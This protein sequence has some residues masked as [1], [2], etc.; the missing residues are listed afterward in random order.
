MESNFPGLL[1]QDAA[2]PLQNL[3][4]ASIHS[5][6]K[7]SRDPCQKEIISRLSTNM[8]RLQFSSEL[9]FSWAEGVFV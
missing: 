1:A 7:Y 2:I 6:A 5:I 9:N 3:D 8:K 4:G